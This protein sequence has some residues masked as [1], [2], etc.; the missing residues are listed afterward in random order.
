MRD[1]FQLSV[2]AKLKIDNVII[3]SLDSILPFGSSCLSEYRPC[4]KIDGGSLHE[5]GVTDY[6]PSRPVGCAEHF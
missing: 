1:R 4:C 3:D 6:D 2:F 5:H